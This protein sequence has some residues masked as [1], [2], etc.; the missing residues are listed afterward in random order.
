MDD[1]CNFDVVLKNHIEDYISAENDASQTGS[2]FFSG[3]AS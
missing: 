2:E 1:A 3:S